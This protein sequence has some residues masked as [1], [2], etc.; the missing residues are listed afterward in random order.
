MTNPYAPPRKSLH[1]EIL[2]DQAAQP[3]ARPIAVGPDPLPADPLGASLAGARL[4]G[5]VH[6]AR[7]RAELSKEALDLY[8]HAAV[9]SMRAQVEVLVQGRNLQ[10]S[11]MRRAQ[12]DAFLEQ[13]HELV[14][15]LWE[16]LENMVNSMKDGELESVI[17]AEAEARRRQTDIIA[18]RDRGEIDPA[19]ADRLLAVVDDHRLYKARHAT[20]R[21]EEFLQ[22]LARHF[23]ETI[24]RLEVDAK[25]YV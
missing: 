20:A 4:T 2:P 6:R 7:A 21:S 17:L 13:N 8:K 22:E 5:I 18:R 11:A 15:R 14:S 24:K 3:L 10:A 9:Q 23:H 25:S 12:F 19:A 1:G 16:R